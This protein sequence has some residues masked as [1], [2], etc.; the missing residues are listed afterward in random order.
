MPEGTDPRPGQFPQEFPCY[1]TYGS[2][3]FEP[4]AQDLLPQYV[5]YSEGQSSTAP[6][7]P[8]VMESL[9]EVADP[10]LRQIVQELLPC[11]ISEST[12]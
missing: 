3:S 6:D 5:T 8:C 7:D 12:G 4:G 11:D 2:A 10:H 1:G 9:P